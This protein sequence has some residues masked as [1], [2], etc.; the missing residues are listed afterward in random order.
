MAQTLPRAWEGGGVHLTR[1]GH[2]C[3]LVEAAGARILVDPG[4]FSHGFE[5]LT[6]LDAVLVTH[7]HPDHIDAERL[8]LLLEANDGARLVAEP[9]IAAQLRE[10][11]FD[12]TALHPGESVSLAGATVTGAGGEHAEIHA[13]IPLVGNVG[14][15]VSGEGEPTLFHPGDSYGAT[16]DGV[17]VLAIP[18]TAPWARV[19]MT[20]DFARAVGAPALVPIHDAVVSPEG[21]GIYVR[22]LSGLLPEASTFHDIEQGSAWECPA[23]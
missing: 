14:M 7:Q 21:R 15:L 13:D 3:L 22:V 20:V 4:A 11:G 23:G 1:Y 10:S 2:S 9:E 12:A 5:E 16:P 17:D 19:G 8:P 18:L 6:G